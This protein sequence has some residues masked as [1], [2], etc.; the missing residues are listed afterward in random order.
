LQGVNFVLFHTTIPASVPI[1]ENFRLGHRGLGVVIHPNTRI[2]ARVTISHNVTLATDLPLSDPRRMVVD[3]DV[4]IG[5]GAVLV[6][7]V[8]LGR[9][10]TIGAGAVVTSDVSPGATMVGN[11]ARELSR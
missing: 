5:T 11:P 8:Q 1:G 2:G 3:D 4:T 7:P 6:G 9:G 10:C